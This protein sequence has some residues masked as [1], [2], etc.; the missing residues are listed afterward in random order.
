MPTLD[1]GHL[2]LTGLYPVRTDLRQADGRTIPWSHHLREELALLPTAQQ[3]PE[4]AEAGLVS[5][6]A[7]CRRTHFARLVVIDQPMWGG[8]DPVDPILN[9]L[10]RRRLKEQ[11][12]YDILSRPWLL[13]A[14]DIDRTDEPD[15]GLARWARHMWAVAEPEMRAIFE[16]T[17][18][19]DTV[20]DG[21]GF[22]RFL[23]RG[24]IETTMSFNGYYDGEPVLKGPGAVRLLALPAAA[25]AGLVLLA[26][27]LGLEGALPWSLLILAAIALFAALGLWQI[28]RAGRRPFPPFP[29]SD[30]G[31]VLK[32]LFLQQRLAAF[33][34]DHQLD[35]PDALHRSFARFLE[36]TRPCDPDPAF[37]QPPGV[38]R[39]D[40]VPLEKPLL[41]PLG[42]I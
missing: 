33:A 25:A 8:R 24:Q 7:R 16:A 35:S 19:F 31:T 39:S 37:A 6:F 1:G 14:A 18:G 27:W 21:E 38:I 29:D 26:C 4:T 34:Q 10:L 2:Y 12:P 22:A 9:I 20:Q 36:E 15:G 11:P 30:L 40:G 17:I 28:S 23:A 5:P 3:N 13:F 41:R 32:A 42:D